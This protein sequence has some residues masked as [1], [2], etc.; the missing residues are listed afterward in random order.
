MLYK[1]LKHGKATLNISIPYELLRNGTI[2]VPLQDLSVLWMDQPT[3]TVIVTA[4]ETL[5]PVAEPAPADQEPVIS[6]NW[7]ESDDFIQFLISCINEHINTCSGTNFSAFSFNGIVYLTPFSLWSYI[8]LYIKAKGIENTDS[9]QNTMILIVKNLIQRGLAK[10]DEIQEGS[11]TAVYRITANKKD[12]KLKP[13]GV[14]IP[15]IANY[16]NTD[17]KKEGILTFISNVE[18]HKEAS[19]VE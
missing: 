1:L 6:D 19:D 12:I 13:K 18:L 17:N 3:Q 8:T 11:Y 15:L 10:A 5:K 14:Y 7:Y 9:K 4:T 16:F 2:E